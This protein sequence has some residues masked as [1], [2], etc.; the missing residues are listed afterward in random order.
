MRGYEINRWTP[1]RIELARTL[2][3]EGL[4]TGEIAKRL[5]VTKN[6]VIGIA[7]RNGFPGRASPIKPGIAAEQRARRN[8]YKRA[9]Y[10][11]QLEAMQKAKASLP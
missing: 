4:K 5:E 3:V 11:R 9:Y 2:W 6:A 10:R 1:D 8:A 7:H